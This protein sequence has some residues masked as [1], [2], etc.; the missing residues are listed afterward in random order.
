LNRDVFVIYSSWMWWKEWHHQF[1][2]HLIWVNGEYG[3]RLGTFDLDS[4]FVEKG[5]EDIFIDF[6]DL[7]VI[8]AFDVR[9]R[10][11]DRIGFVRDL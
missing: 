8:F 3:K 5:V 6:K 1:S 9:I 11:M 10:E 4:A 7:V 2:L